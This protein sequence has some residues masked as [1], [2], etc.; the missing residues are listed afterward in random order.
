MYQKRA[1][2]VKA[3]KFPP[4]TAR[5]LSFYAKISP[6]LLDSLALSDAVGGAVWQKKFKECLFMV[7]ASFVPLGS[8]PSP[9]KPLFHHA[10]LPR[11][12]LFPSSHFPSKKVIIFAKSDCTTRKS[13]FGFAIAFQYEQRGAKMLRSIKKA[14]DMVK[15][16]DPDTAITV[17]TIRMWCKE[18]KIKCLTAGNKILVDVQSLMDYIC[19]I[20]AHRRSAIARWTAGTAAAD[21]HLRRDRF[22]QV[23]CQTPRR[24]AWPLRSF[25]FAG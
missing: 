14:F 6:C 16:E 7:C 5:A 20:C 12:S 22:R 17:H 21:I 15:Q 13:A 2:A 18:G 10:L 11:F 8:P 3:E 1:C 23:G 25:L 24:R 19:P 4:K 9:L